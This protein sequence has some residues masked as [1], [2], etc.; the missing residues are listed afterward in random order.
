MS[1]KFTPLV[2]SFIT[3]F[4]LETFLFY[5]KSVYFG[6][7]LINLFFLFV[8]IE[9]YSLKEYKKLFNYFIL[10]SLLTIGITIYSTML[11]N[12]TIIQCLFVLNIFF[13][14]WYFKVIY[15]FIVKKSKKIFSSLENILS[16]GNFLSFFFISASLYGLYSR[17]SIPIIIILGVMLIIF[18]LLVHN[19]IFVFSLNKEVKNKGDF[20]KNIIHIA[21][22][23]LILIEL[24]CAL[25]FLP[26]N[27][28][29]IG[30]I[31]AIC[32]YMLIG[33]AKYYLFVGEIA[34]RKIKLYLGFGFSA[35]FFILATAEWL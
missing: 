29:M 27:H 9:L 34:K 6:L 10:P 21:V 28:E 16:F 17:L 30:L 7:I 11:A 14:F 19:I 35:I 26:F 13:I 25:S 20:K 22:Y 18:I 15:L 31:L 4:F 32:Y 8:L 23:C 1:S 33:L 2:T 3:F 12:R 24:A 5:P